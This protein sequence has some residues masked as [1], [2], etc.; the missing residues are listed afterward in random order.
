MIFLCMFLGFAETGY[1]GIE[2]YSNVYE[3]FQKV[4]I[5]RNSYSSPEENTIV[6][7]EVVNIEYITQTVILGEKTDVCYS[8]G[9]NGWKY[10]QS[11]G[12]I[13]DL[14]IKYGA[15]EGISYIVNREK[16]AK[17]QRYF[18][19]EIETYPI[20]QTINNLIDVIEDSEEKLKVK[21]LSQNAWDS[22]IRMEFIILSLSYERDGEEM[23]DDIDFIDKLK[24]KNASGNLFIY[25]Y[26]DDT[27]VYIYDNMIKDKAV[28]V[29]VPHVQ[30][31]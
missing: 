25:N 29:Y 26:N 24:N 28:V 30:D 2:W 15:L 27:R 3:V 5:C 14:F 4:P 13:D 1:R 18:E 12:D 7:E 23:F 11:H 19:K 9:N 10:R 22:I 20:T 16:V 6:E 8:F 17:L 21:N 31:Y